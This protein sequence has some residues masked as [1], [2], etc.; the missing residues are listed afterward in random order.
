VLPSLFPPELHRQGP[1]LI[2]A[3]L[4]CRPLDA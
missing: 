2:A 4:L 1:T 3:L